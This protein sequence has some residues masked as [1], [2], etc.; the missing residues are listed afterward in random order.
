MVIYNINIDEL[1]T[2]LKFDGI[3][4]SD[5]SDEELTVLVN[6]KIQ[7]LESYIGVDIY[8]VDRTQITHNWNGSV[9]ELDHY[10]I[11][12]VAHL[13]LNDKTVCRSDYN[14][15]YNL[16]VIYFHKKHVKPPLH[17]YPR[18]FGKGYN[19]TRGD[20]IKVEYTTGLDERILT[21][22]VVP[23]IKDMLGYT[24]SLA[25]ANQ[26][27]GGLAGFVNSVKEGDLSM[28]FGSVGANSGGN[29]VNYGYNN[30]INNRIDELKRK[31]QYNS[32]VK[33]I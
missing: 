3:D 7:E 12:Q 22:M 27:L 18:R 6:A 1:K 32:R 24:F 4:L 25:K 30:G 11:L 13:Y 2:L 21:S 17:Y 10:P 26:K 14:V 8:P 15:D 19:R 29:G 5:I 33:L 16:G 31:Y 28:N 9:Y 20:V 23:L